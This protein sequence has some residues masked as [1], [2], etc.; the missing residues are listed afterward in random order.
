MTSISSI[1]IKPA[2]FAVSGFIQFSL[3]GG[4]EQR[5]TF[6]R[7]TFDA[8]GDENSMVIHGDES[9]FRA[10]RDAIEEAQRKL[11]QPRTVQVAQQYGDVFEQLE[12]LARLRDSGILS[13]SEF[14]SKK[15][16]L[17]ARM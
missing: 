13:D 16:E 10:L 5:S 15:A 1:Q 2:G 12:K 7:Q 17:L 14:E 3:A 9:D 8:A 11:H 4:N 6:G